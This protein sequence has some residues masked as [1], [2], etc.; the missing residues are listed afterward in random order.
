MKETNLKPGTLATLSKMTLSH[1]TGT[2]IDNCFVEIL[3]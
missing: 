2:S 3:P 1:P